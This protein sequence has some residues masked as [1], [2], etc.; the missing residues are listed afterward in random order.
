MF[1][2]GFAFGIVFSVL[3]AP[4]AWQLYLAPWLFLSFFYPKIGEWVGGKW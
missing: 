2:T 3:V 1:L 4:F